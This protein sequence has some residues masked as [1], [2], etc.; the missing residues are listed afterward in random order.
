MLLRARSGCDA[1]R[2]NCATSR[3]NKQKRS[4]ADVRSGDD[5][6]HPSSGDLMRYDDFLPSPDQNKA[7]Y[8]LILPHVGRWFRDSKIFFTDVTTTDG[9]T[10]DDC[11]AHTDTPAG[12]DG[13]VKTGLRSSSEIHVTLPAPTVVLPGCLTDPRHLVV[14]PQYLRF[15]TWTGGESD[16]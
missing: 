13:R 16:G 5:S 2:T 4:F 12:W 10:G 6:S 1:N 11:A 3:D 7:P 9:Q 8:C 15:S 14:R